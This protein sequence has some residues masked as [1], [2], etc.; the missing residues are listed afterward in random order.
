ME[1]PQ[2]KRQTQEQQKSS[3]SEILPLP[4]EVQVLAKDSRCE[5]IG[6]WLDRFLTVNPQNYEHTQNA[7]RR[8]WVIEPAKKQHMQEGVKAL[9][10]RHEA[11]LQ[12]KKQQ[13]YVVKCFKAEPVWRFVVGLGAAHVLETSI[14]LHRIFGLP[15]IPGSALKGAAKAYAQLI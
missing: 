12:W 13:S 5:N 10:R 4:Y 11:I 6:L 8:H 14:T 7:K 3:L 1:R 15:I 2:R 9:K